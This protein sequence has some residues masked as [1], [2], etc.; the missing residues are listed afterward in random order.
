M[1]ISSCEMKKSDFPVVSNLLPLLTYQKPPKVTRKGG[2][3][4]FVQSN[5]QSNFVIHRT[6]EVQPPN[7]RSF[8]EKV[9]QSEVLRVKLNVFTL[10]FTRTDA[11]LVTHLWVIMVTERQSRTQPKRQADGMQR[12]PKS[13]GV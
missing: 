7:S 11:Q 13:L 3:F 4:N 6:F 9:G 5:L 8:R 2:K 12:E 1:C 10:V